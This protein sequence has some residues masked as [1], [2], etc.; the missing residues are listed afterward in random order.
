MVLESSL[1][2]LVVELVIEKTLDGLVHDGIEATK[3][4]LMP[5]A[6]LVVTK[7]R[8]LRSVLGLRWTRSTSG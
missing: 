6:E 4:A 7:Q 2:S 8:A 5:L 1:L 3:V